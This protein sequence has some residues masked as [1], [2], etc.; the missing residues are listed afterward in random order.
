MSWAVVAIV[1]ILGVAPVLAL[2]LAAD[3][4]S[5]LSLLFTVVAIDKTGHKWGDESVVALKVTGS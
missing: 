2:A 3:V 1:A 4:G 5:T